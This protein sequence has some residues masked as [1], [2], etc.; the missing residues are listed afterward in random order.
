MSP[1]FIGIEPA[2]F[3]QAGAAVAPM[4]DHAAG[5]VA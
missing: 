4:R 1:S 5:G 3:L 2:A